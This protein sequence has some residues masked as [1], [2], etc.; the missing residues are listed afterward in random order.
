MSRYNLFRDDD[1][2]Y[3]TDIGLLMYAHDLI[4]SYKKQHAVAVLMDRLWDNKEVWLWLMTTPNLTIGL[5][6]WTHRDYSLVSSTDAIEDIQRSLAYWSEHTA[7][8]PHVPQLAIFFPPWN[9]TSPALER[10]CYA[11]G[12]RVDVRWKKDSDVYGF[13]SWELLLQDR[14]RKLEEA[15]RA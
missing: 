12:L 1:I 3:T 5:H 10:A 4:T 14:K 13:H 9:K 15:L 6:G 7:A 11:T 2:S 8:Y